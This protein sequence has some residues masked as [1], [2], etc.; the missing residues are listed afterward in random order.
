MDI[1]L[2]NIENESRRITFRA[3][4]GTIDNTA[5]HYLKTA[6][7]IDLVDVNVH[8]TPLATDFTKNNLFKS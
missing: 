8:A 7:G 5:M 6:N 1:L 2:L 4:V 3:D